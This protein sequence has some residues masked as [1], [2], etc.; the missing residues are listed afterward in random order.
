MLTFVQILHTYIHFTV[1]CANLS[2]FDTQV[3]VEK[4]PDFCSTFQ[5]K[6]VYEGHFY[7]W[8]GNFVEYPYDEFDTAL[9]WMQ[10]FVEISGQN[11]SAPFWMGEFG[12][13][14]NSVQWQKIIRFIR[15]HDL[16]W[17]IWTLDGYQ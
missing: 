3:L 13:G 11:Y 4:Y 15:E 9:T 7:S 5:S 8:F 17:A 6:L 14:S 1:T 12:T 16:D 10:R 2:F